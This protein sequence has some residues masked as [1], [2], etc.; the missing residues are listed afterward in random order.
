MTKPRK[1]GLVNSPAGTARN[2]MWRLEE[3][4]PAEALMVVAAWFCEHVALSER[5]ESAFLAALN[6]KWGRTELGY[7]VIEARDGTEVENSDGIARL[8]GC[9]SCDD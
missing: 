2:L 9:A 8:G 1:R 6:L 4:E 5:E 7:P 3:S